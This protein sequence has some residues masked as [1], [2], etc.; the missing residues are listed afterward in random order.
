M[1]LRVPKNKAVL[2]LKSLALLMI[3]E[4]VTNLT[5]KRF[6]HLQIFPKIKICLLFKAL[7]PHKIS[8]PMSMVLALLPSYKCTW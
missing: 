2:V 5:T 1:H 3:L 4:P 8:A 6:M 7:S